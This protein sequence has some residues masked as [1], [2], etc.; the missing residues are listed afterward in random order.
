[1]ISIIIPTHNRPSSLSRSLDS[2]LESLKGRG[3]IIVIDDGSEPPVSIQKYPNEKVK[4]FRNAQPCG[5]SAARNLGVSEAREDIILFLDDDDILNTNYV[6]RILDIRI[7]NTFAKF[8]FSNYYIIEN[9]KKIK[10][11][12]SKAGYSSKYEKLKYRLSGLG[13][14]FWIE[15]KLFLDLGGLDDRLI[16][17]EDTDL[18]VR[19]AAKNIL[20]WRET[21]PGVFIER[22]DTIR[23]T[24]SLSDTDVALSYYRTMQKNVDSFGTWSESR[25]YLCHRALKKCIKAGLLEIAKKCIFNSGNHIFKFYL[26][27]FYHIYLHR[28][29]IRI[30]NMTTA[31]NAQ[32]DKKTFEHRS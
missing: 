8:G 16:I 27:I 28:V 12:I 9:D 22:N 13:M 15:R 3:E 18:C 6:D 17:D 29:R 4:L 25:Y 14:G 20:P 5:A 19:L 11:R 7:K 10:G 32:A 1:M 26:I 31:A 24:N 30:Q 23:L 21:V 2:A